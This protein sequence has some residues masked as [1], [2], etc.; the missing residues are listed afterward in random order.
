M[1]R[2]RLEQL[3]QENDGNLTP[4]TSAPT[5]VKMAPFCYPMEQLTLGVCWLA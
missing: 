3:Q 2:R 4:A 5:P 1:E